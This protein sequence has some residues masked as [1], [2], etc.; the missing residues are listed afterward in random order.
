MSPVDPNL[1]VGRIATL[2]PQSIAVFERFGIDYCCAGARTL[3]EACA[4]RCL[5]PAFMVAAIARSAAPRAQAGPDWET[6]PLPALVEHIEHR[7][8]RP[9]AG[10]L[11]RL[12][13]LLLKVVGVHRAEHPRQMA[14]L[15]IAF[16]ALRQKVEPHVQKEEDVVFALIRAHRG[17][18]LAGAVKV[19]ARE[20]EE[21]GGCL[22]YLREVTNG[23]FAPAAACGSWRVLWEGLGALDAGLRAQIHLEN[24]VLFPRVLS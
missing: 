14:A 24:N 19:L 15:D 4:A 17:D 11:D 18:T 7:Y 13:S 1:T 16:S 3:R 23:Y 2:Y 10:D 8:H 5:D 9:L 22:H 21:V 12:G 20:H 6:A